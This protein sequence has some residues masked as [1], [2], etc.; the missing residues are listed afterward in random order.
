MCACG[1]TKVFGFIRLKKVFIESLHIT[2]VMSTRRQYYMLPS[3]KLR[4]NEWV[5]PILCNAKILWMT[6]NNDIC[7]CHE[8]IIH[9]NSFEESIRKKYSTLYFGLQMVL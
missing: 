8:K 5:T 4:Y 1:M 3:T 7:M 6:V 9:I 2:A